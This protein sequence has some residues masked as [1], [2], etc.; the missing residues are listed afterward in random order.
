MPPSQAMRKAPRIAGTL[1][2]PMFSYGVIGQIDVART[3]LVFAHTP[4]DF[5]MLAYKLPM[6]RMEGII[7]DRILRSSFRDTTE[8]SRLIIPDD[9]LSGHTTQH[10]KTVTA[11]F[12]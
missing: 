7:A 10:E 8:A 5:Y 6:I 9:A 4:E 12:A 1:G 11:I 3:C 2:K